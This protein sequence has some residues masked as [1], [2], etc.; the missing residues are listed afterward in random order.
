LIDSGIADSNKQ[1]KIR[2]EG[3][4]APGRLVTF[5]AELILELTQNTKVLF[6]YSR[7]VCEIKW[8]IRK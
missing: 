6:L 2:S 7:S 4:V 1:I 5:A 8:L 3:F